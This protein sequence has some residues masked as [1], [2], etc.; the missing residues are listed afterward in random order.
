MSTSPVVTFQNQRVSPGAFD[1]A[2]RRSSSHTGPF[3]ASAIAVSQLGF[4]HL[5]GLTAQQ[6][7]LS[8]Y[9]LWRAWPVASLCGPAVLMLAGIV[10]YRTRLLGRLMGI[11]GIAG[12]AIATVLTVKPEALRLTSLLGQGYAFN[13]VL[14]D[15][16]ASFLAAALCGTGMVVLGLRGLTRAAPVPPTPSCLPA[17]AGTR[18]PRSASPPC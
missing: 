5:G 1:A 16:N 18:P 11:G 13:D 17:P 12:M 2:R 9:L 14:R 15:T 3:D 6:M 4:A 7:S 8:Q 10:V